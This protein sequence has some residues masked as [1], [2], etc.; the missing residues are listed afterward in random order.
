MHHDRGYEI[1]LLESNQK[2]DNMERLEIENKLAEIKA[3]FDP[4][5]EYSDDQSV[6]RYHHELQSLIGKLEHDLKVLNAVHHELKQEADEL[7]GIK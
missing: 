2:G 1:I 3:S 6:W 5:F 4:F 7:F